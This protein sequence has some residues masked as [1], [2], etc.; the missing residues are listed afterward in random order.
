MILNDT[1]EQQDLITKKNLNT[2]VKK[3]TLQE[4]YT[5]FQSENEKP[6]TWLDVITQNLPSIAKIASAA[7]IKNPYQQGAIQESLSGEQSRQEATRQAYQQAQSQKQ[8]DFMDIAYKQAVLD[9]DE[10]AGLNKKDW[11]TDLGNIYRIVKDPN[12]SKEDK[13]FISKYVMYNKDPERVR[14]LKY[15]GA[16]GKGAGELVHAEQIAKETETGKQTGELNFM[17]KKEYQKDY[18]DIRNSAK[19]AKNMNYTYGQMEQMLDTGIRTGSLANVEL[20]AKKFLSVFGIDSKGIAE[21]QAFKALGNQLALRMRNPD[22]GFGLTGTTS[23]KDINFLKSTVPQLTNT[24]EG[25]SLI[26]KLAKEI[27]NRKIEQANIAEKYV[28]ENGYY[29]PVAINKKIDELNNTS[30][31]SEDLIKQVEGMVGGSKVKENY[32]IKVR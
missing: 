18:A 19:E 23:D 14:N 22:S 4:I 10:Q 31:F 30:M 20:E 27:N 13:D 9:N 5:K 28:Q 12:T 6:M 25:N 3:P 21:G 26:I 15:S 11:N 29:D 1:L 24:P 16:E 32:T 17:N 7:F 8:K 2:N